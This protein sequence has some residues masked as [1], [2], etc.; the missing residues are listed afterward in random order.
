MD[1]EIHACDFC[2]ALALATAGAL[3]KF[4]E[5]D[6]TRLAQFKTGRN[7]HAVD[8]EACLPFKFEEEIHQPCVTGAAAEN[9]PAATQD[10][11]GE[12]LDEA[13]RLFL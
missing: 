4:G 8:I 5:S 1:F 3:A 11:A 7:E 13:P 6:V 10:S 12:A 2:P 9:P